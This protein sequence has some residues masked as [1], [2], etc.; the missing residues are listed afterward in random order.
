MGYRVIQT[1]YWLDFNL[2]RFFFIKNIFIYEKFD[3][4]LQ[5][6]G[7]WCESVPASETDKDRMTG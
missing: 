4:L 1:G 5:N 2:E 3:R 6:G 7:N